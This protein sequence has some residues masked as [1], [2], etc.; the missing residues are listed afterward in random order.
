MRQKQ[1]PRLASTTSISLLWYLALPIR[2]SQP[3]PHTQLIR[4]LVLEAIGNVPAQD[5][6]KLECTVSRQYHLFRA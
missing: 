1:T 5:R 4:R 2:Y 6:R 3:P